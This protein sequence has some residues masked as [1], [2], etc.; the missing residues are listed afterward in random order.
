MSETITMR[1][2]RAVQTSAFDPPGL[3]QYRVFGETFRRGGIEDRRPAR[4]GIDVLDG[5][6]ADRLASDAGPTESDDARLVVTVEPDGQV[7][8]LNTGRGAF[9]LPPQRAR[10]LAK[11]L[12]LAASDGDYQGRHRPRIA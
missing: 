7:I 9:K 6:E 3:D 11:E 2:G 5:R 1:H 4:V 8:V 12:V 10:E